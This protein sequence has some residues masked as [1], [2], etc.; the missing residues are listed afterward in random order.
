[1]EVGPYRHDHHPGKRTHHRW[2]HLNCHTAGNED[3]ESDVHQSALANEVG[4][5]LLQRCITRPGCYRLH[6]DRSCFRG[7]GQD[8]QVV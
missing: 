3:S 8:S 5:Y 6:Q 1:M 2:H 7:A 4:S